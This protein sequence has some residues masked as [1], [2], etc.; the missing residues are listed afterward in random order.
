M[1]IRFRQSQESLD[2][3]EKL[4]DIFSYL[5]LVGLVDKLV[6]GAR[7]FFGIYFR[8]CCTFSDKPGSCDQTLYQPLIK[9]TGDYYITDGLGRLIR[10]AWGKIG[11]ELDWL[12]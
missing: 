7:K 2:S 1:Y 5:L 9:C 8:E 11:L 6:E 12:L 4:L 3:A 10:Q